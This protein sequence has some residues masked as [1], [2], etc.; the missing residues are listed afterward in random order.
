MLSFEDALKLVAL[1]GKL[2][3]ESGEK[4]PGT[5]AA[6]VGLDD[7]SVEKIC[8]DLNG[9]DGNVLVPANYNAPG[10]VVISGSRDFVRGSLDAFKE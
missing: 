6:V 2:M 1:R 8:N 7:A 4:T 5:M 3:F 9:T 10:Q